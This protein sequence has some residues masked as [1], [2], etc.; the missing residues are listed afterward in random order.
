MSATKRMMVDEAELGPDLARRVERAVTDVGRTLH[1]HLGWGEPDPRQELPQTIWIDWLRDDVRICLS[2]DDAIP[3][4]YLDVSMPSL[5]ECLAVS[6]ILAEHVKTYDLDTLQRLAR[7]RL[8]D[9]PR[10]LIRLGLAWIGGE[11]SADLLQIIGDALASDNPETRW[12]AAFV[13]NFL[14][15]PSLRPAVRG[16]HDQE[17]DPKLKAM[18]G[19]VIGRLTE[20]GKAPG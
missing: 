1:L 12:G 4:A 20:S 18:L 6:D 16:A 8:H 5:E 3:A 11:Q 7:E 10:W 19:Q 15:W 2:Q 9:E 17:H 13:C 14:R